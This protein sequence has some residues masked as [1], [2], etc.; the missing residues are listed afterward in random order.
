MTVEQRHVAHIGLR[1]CRDDDFDGR[2]LVLR[3][4]DPRIGP[5][6]KGRISDDDGH[7]MSPEG[8]DRRLVPAPR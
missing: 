3:N 6:T 5:K 8:Y 2:L 1:R 7:A 4:P